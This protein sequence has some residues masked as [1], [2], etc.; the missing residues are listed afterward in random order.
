M[1][2]TLCSRLLGS[3][4]DSICSSHESSHKRQMTNQSQTRPDTS[5]SGY[6]ADRE[7]TSASPPVVSIDLL[8]NYRRNGLRDP[9]G[10]PKRRKI[11]EL[12][13]VAS[14]AKADLARAGVQYQVIAK[15]LKKATSR[16]GLSIDLNGVRLMHSRDVEAPVVSPSTSAQ[17]LDYDYAAL[18]FACSSAYSN[19]TSQLRQNTVFRSSQNSVRS[20]STVSDTESDSGDSDTNGKSARQVVSIPALFEDSLDTDKQSKPELKRS[21][22][23][24]VSCAA[25]AVTMCEM[26]QL[27][28]TAR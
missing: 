12:Q 18:A 9:N 24:I 11:N 28:K 4:V 14:S 25:N 21:S 13:F 16:G 17:S 23:L 27:S 26:L 1:V 20:T 6:S 19:S 2:S 3:S 22:S 7:E 15:D 8:G 10:C 5:V